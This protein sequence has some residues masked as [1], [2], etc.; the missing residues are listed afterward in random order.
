MTLTIESESWQSIA[1]QATKEMNT[2]KLLALITR[3]C[4]ALDD[5]HA[6]TSDA[7]IQRENAL[8][9]SFAD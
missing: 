9:Y 2:T 5:E 7:R 6:N 8:A 3:L 1:E 4:R